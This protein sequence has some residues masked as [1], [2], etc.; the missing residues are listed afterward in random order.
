MRSIGLPHHF[1]KDT[2]MSAITASAVKGTA[3][4][5]RAGMMDAKKRLKK[6]MATSKPQLICSRKGPCHCCQEIEPPRGRCLLALL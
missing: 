3:R 2:I 5:F 1:E 4:A 6:P